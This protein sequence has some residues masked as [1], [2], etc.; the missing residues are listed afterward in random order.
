MNPL[1]LAASLTLHAAV[2]VWLV[3][4]LPD[5]GERLESGD[6]ATIEV[7]MEDEADTRPRLP[8]EAAPLPERAPTRTP[9]PSPPA[10]EPTPEPAGQPPATTAA[11]TPE[12]ETPEA[13]TPEAETPEPEPRE[14]AEAPTEP[15]PAPP[16]A[17]E[18]EPAAPEDAPRAEPAPEMAALAEPPRRRPPRP[19]A[20]P[21]PA[22]EEPEPAQE[23]PEPVPEE[24]E[25]APEPA[26]EA[27]APEPVPE[28]TETAAADGADGAAQPDPDTRQQEADEDSDP[29]DALLQSVEELARRV[30]AE[31]AREGTGD[32]EVESPTGRLAELR[33]QRLGQLIY[34]QIVGCWNPPAGVDGLREV[35]A[36]EIRAEFRQN[37]EVVSAEVADQD[38]LATDRA[39]RSVAESARRAVFNCAPL[40]GMP[41]EFYQQW[42]VV[43]LEF[44]P[45]QIAAGG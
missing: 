9:E 36:V 33:A 23:E 11:E 15:A 25:P 21:E 45:D 28:P 13:E 44:R 27:P 14:T 22:P 35:G 8:A 40:Q 7:V 16:E 31:E 34:E 4:A 20:E 26:Q 3:I 10:A 43:I 6:V 17:P 2:L 29:V 24:P 12:P 18:P 41:G 5:F 30:E 32:A 1:A 19:E 39:F 42:R 37:G 38:R